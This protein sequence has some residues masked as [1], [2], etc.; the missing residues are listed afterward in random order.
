MPNL[1]HFEQNPQLYQLIS[2][3]NVNSNWSNFYLIDVAWNHT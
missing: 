1:S 2:K 3:F